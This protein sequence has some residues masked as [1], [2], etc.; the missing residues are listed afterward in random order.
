MC[1]GAIRAYLADEVIID[2]VVLITCGEFN[3][4]IDGVVLI[5]LR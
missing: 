2:G 3:V 5:T 4:I 1:F